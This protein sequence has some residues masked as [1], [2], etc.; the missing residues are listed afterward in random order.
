[1][2]TEA[3]I[4]LWKHSK[5]FFFNQIVGRA[6]AS[7]KRNASPVSN[8]VLGDLFEAISSAKKYLQI[9]FPDGRTAFVKEADCLAY[10]DW[11][12]QKPNVDAVLSIAK[13]MIGNPYMWGGTS[14]RRLTVRG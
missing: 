6:V 10:E 4:T 12:A 13:Q 8:L 2:E 1:M 9:K 11:I 7:P 3:E 14:A 5:R